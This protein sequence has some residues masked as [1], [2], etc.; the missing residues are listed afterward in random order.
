LQTFPDSF[1]FEGTMKKAM[2]QIGNAVP[3]RLAECIA[4]ALIP[5]LN[6]IVTNDRS[7]VV[8][9]KLFTDVQLT[10]H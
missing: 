8:S 7:F 9:E 1:I 2:W 6:A 4:Y 3:P 5:C 10:L